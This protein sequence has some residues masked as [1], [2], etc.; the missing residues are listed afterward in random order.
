MNSD[1]L[2]IVETDLM[3]V[4]APLGFS[5]ADSA[6]S[7]SFDNAFVIV[8]GADVRLRV[9]RERGTVFLDLAPTPVPN[10]WVDSAVVM[11]FLGLSGDGGFHGRET[12]EVVAGIG[13]FITGLLSELEVTFNKEQWSST[14]QALQDLKER[15]ARRLFG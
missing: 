11:D 13:A 7:E 9:L 12:R 3:P 14:K 15:R 6:V 5:I 2:A 4:L 8:E 1:L 10:D